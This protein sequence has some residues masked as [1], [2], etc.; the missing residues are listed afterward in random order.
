LNEGFLT[1]HID[2]APNFAGTLY[3]VTNCIASIPSFVAPQTAGLMTNGAQTLSNWRKVFF[4]AA[5]FY[6]SGSIFF[7]FFADGEVQ[8][9]NDE[10]YMKKSTAVETAD[11]KKRK[12]EVEKM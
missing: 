6:A 3:G 12:T 9:W 4:I 2:I 5:A 8:D 1:N 11:D 10:N 7:A